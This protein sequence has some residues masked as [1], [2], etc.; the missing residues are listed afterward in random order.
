M[1]SYT[2]PDILET[3]ILGWSKTYDINIDVIQ[4]WGNVQMGSK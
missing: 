4:G 3:Y 1:E 2:K